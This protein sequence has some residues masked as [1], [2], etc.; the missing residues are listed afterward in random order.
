MIYWKW[1]QTILL[2]DDVICSNC[3]V[4]GRCNQ[5]GKRTWERI[6]RHVLQH[7][8]MNGIQEKKKHKGREQEKKRKR[9]E[10]KSGKKR[11]VGPKAGGHW[12]NCLPAATRPSEW[13]ARV[14]GYAS[15][16]PGPPP[17][18]SVL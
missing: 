16:S 5:S 14:G 9:T 4:T 10:G 2:N 1:R 17:L 3:D 7:C 11:A 15:H 18:P 6:N 12:R 13:Q 8:N